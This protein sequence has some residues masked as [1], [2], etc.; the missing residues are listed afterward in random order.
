[1]TELIQEDD[2][3]PTPQKRKPK[4]CT[5]THCECNGPPASKKPVWTIHYEDD[6]DECGIPIGCAF[7]RY[8]SKYE[9]IMNHQYEQSDCEVW[10]WIQE[11]KNHIGSEYVIF[12]IKH[13]WDNEIL[14]FYSKDESYK[15]YVYGGSCLFEKINVKA[16]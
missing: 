16:S 15:K 3:E 2:R 1:M 14:V 4:I 9:K 5:N 10:K 8:H 11:V 7:I 6:E 12:N 13:K